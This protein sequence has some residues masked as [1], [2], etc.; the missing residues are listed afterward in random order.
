MKAEVF[1]KKFD[2]DNEEIICDL[3]LSTL[4]TVVG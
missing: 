4:K 1:D 3:D 2:D